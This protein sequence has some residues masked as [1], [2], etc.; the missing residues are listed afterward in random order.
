VP[1]DMMVLTISTIPTI[2]QII[3]SIL[4]RSTQI[5]TDGRP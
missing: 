5:T 1:H 4:T 2:A 3:T